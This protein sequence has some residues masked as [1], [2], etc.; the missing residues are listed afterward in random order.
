M[1]KLC[2]TAVRG[3]GANPRRRVDPQCQLSQGDKDDDASPRP[4]AH[5]STRLGD[6]AVGCPD[7]PACVTMASVTGLQMTLTMGTTT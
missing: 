3:A 5:P 7:P 2:M 4:L 6:S 1:Y